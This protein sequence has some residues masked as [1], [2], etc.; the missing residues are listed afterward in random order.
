M[1]TTT[2]HSRAGQMRYCPVIETEDEMYAVNSTD[3]GFC[4]GCGSIRSGVEPDA[5][6]YPCEVCGE[7]L[8]YG[9]QE[10]LFMDLLKF[11]L[12]DG[13]ERP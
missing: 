12:D 3:E 13:D 11:A 8:V 1:R 7:H 6:R 10:L 5:R 9:F 4:V 2:Y